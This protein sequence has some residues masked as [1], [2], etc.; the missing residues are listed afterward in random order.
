MCYTCSV[1]KTGR[2][3]D[4]LDSGDVSLHFRVHSSTASGGLRKF[5]LCLDCLERLCY[6]LDINS[7]D[8]V[9]S[10]GIFIIDID[11]NN[12]NFPTRRAY[13]AF[14]FYFFEKHSAM[15]YIKLAFDRS[16]NEMD[17]RRS[18]WS[19]LT[20]DWTSMEGRHVGFGGSFPITEPDV[21]FMTEFY[22]RFFTKGETPDHWKVD[23]TVHCLLLGTE[24][25]YTSSYYVGKRIHGNRVRIVICTNEKVLTDELESFES[26]A[27]A[28]VSVLSR[29]DCP[30][31]EFDI[32]TALR[33]VD[34]FVHAPKSGVLGFS[35]LEDD[36]EDV[37]YFVSFEGVRLTIG[38]RS[39][40]NYSKIFGY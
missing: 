7:A 37:G 20:D 31:S 34:E 15:Y 19:T 17:F 9:R 10:N 39:Y 3:A 12:A 27:S 4:Y 25:D 11:L 35:D 2:P 8:V 36:N 28:K 30:L 32:P 1:F 22:V 33:F 40:E 16:V 5:S 29:W 18:T 24:H 23:P 38:A 26:S 6:A 14:L 21:K 13:V